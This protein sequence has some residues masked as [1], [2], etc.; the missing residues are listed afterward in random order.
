MDAYASTEIIDRFVCSALFLVQ[1]R[2]IKANR[3]TQANR[4]NVRKAS[5]Y[6][7]FNGAHQ[8]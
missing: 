8:D 6:A 3:A 5:K 2:R 1:L 7:G 4:L